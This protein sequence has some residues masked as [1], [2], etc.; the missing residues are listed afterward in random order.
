MGWRHREASVASDGQSGDGFGAVLRELRE[1][2]GLSQSGLARQAGLNA[3]FVNR[4][5]SGQ[6]GADRAVVDTLT[7]ALGLGPGDAD[8]LLVASLGLAPE[9]ERR[10]LAGSQLADEVVRL[11]PDDATL[12]RVAAALSDPTLP[13]EERDDL[14]RAV[15]IS[16]DEPSVRRVAR[17]L[18]D[19]SQSDLDRA[20]F[21]QVVETVAR[22]WRH[23]GELR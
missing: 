17:V 1:R 9:Q 12:R 23:A 18:S 8:R 19:P 2:T 10:L 16:L 3:S 7:R 21:R 6:R 13:A 20:D 4:L 22:H 15:E 14:R 11:G 5:E